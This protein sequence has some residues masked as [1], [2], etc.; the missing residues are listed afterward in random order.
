MCVCVSEFSTLRHAYTHTLHFSHQ[1]AKL[2]T[3]D[4][5]N[6]INEKKELEIIDIHHIQSHRNAYMAL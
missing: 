5:G 4:T 2:L 3:N 6:K 1:N